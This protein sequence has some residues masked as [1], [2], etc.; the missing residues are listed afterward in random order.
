MTYQYETE[1]F[2]HQREC[3]EMSRNLPGYAIL[4]EQG[5]GKT[6]PAIDTACYLFEEGKI[7]AVVVLAPPGVHRNWI[8]DE[9]TKHMPI[10]VRKN[11]E[12]GFWNSQ[13]FK[14]KPHQTLFKRLRHFKGLSVA[15]FS[16]PNFKTTHARE[17][18]RDFM[19]NRKVMI[20][21]DE[22]HNIKTFGVEQTKLALAAAKLCPYRRVLTGTPI[23]TGPFDI[24]TQIMFVDDTFWKRKGIST[25]TGFKQ[26]FGVWFTRQECLRT[27]GYD[28]GYNKLIRY[29]NLDVLSE[30]LREIADRKTKD[31]VLDLPPK[32]Y[33]KVY[34]ELSTAQ[35]RLYSQLK[36]ELFAVLDNG[37]V[38]EAPLPIVQLLRFQQIVCGYLPS[39]D[40][41]LLDIGDKNLRLETLIDICDNLPHPAIIWSRFTS[42]LDKIMQALG[43]RACR[44]D[45][46]IGEDACERS[47]IAF[48]AGE[49][50]F[51]VGN[52]QAGGSG[53]TLL[54]ARTVI[55]YANSF[56]LIDRLQSEDRPHRIGQTHP[57][58]YI[59][60][61]AAETVD[62]RIVDCLRS[63]FDIASTIVDANVREWI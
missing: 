55:Y 2:A 29:K 6:K 57:V 27:R 26:Q 23:S 24:Y 30:W 54:P 63:N 36:E 50:Q 62:E 20:I 22:A 58:N 7:D 32:L 47:K 45:G 48:N 14:T 4:W 61:I 17:W 52:P 43:D 35:K 33:S 37:H 53:I 1:P 25:Y 8:N 10:R 42:D 34:V 5:C 51:F 31:E 9:I 41:T 38:V 60:L 46:T 12:T 11:M 18:L 28:P 49:K 19:K 16:Y 3:F 40:G 21:A 13:K 44:Y 15:A 59:D 56:R 39:E